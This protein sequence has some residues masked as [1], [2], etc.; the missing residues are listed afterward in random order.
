MLDEATAAAEAMT[1]A[2]RVSTA[3]DAAVFL[4]DHRVHPQ[5]LAVI[6]TRS[7]PLKIEVLTFDPTEELPA[8]EIFGAMVQYPNTYA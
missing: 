5:T 4:V 1:L 2:R 7:K 3:P 6:Q 8:S